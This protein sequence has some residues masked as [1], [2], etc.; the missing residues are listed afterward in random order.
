MNFLAGNNIIQT[1]AP[2]KLDD[3]SEFWKEISFYDIRSGQR[4]LD[5]GAGNGF[6][7]FIL[8][9]SGIETD[10]YLSEIDESI[11]PYLN[12]SIESVEVIAL[13][14]DLHLIKGGEKN[15][16]TDTMQFDR[17][18]MREVFHHL[19]YPSEIF[20]SIKKNLAENGSVIIVET[21]RDVDI[22][23]Q[24]RCPQST[25]KEKIIEF[26]TAN[27]FRLVESQQANQETMLKFIL[28]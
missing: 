7:S 11:I 10:I 26:V 27:G 8:A 6:I 21:T 22:G 13:S 5:L 16:G 17:I 12:Q 25:T 14:A 18:L 23:K 3:L 4:I 20:S 1:K 24:R 28:K 2:Y 15:I 9:L 19:K